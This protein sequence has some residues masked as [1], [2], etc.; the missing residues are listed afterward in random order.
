MG[1]K[2]WNSEE[3]LVPAVLALESK[4]YVVGWNR[5]EVHRVNWHADGPLGH[6]GGSGPIELLGLIS[7]RET[8]GENWKASDEQTRAFREL[9]EFDSP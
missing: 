3:T 6:F 8:R 4:G 1:E 2:T 5:Y 7:M 9:F